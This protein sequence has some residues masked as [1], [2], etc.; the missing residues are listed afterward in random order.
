MV[1][2]NNT[3]LYNFKYYFQGGRTLK[4]LINE[5]K[6]SQP[7]IEK[8]IED[9]FAKINLIESDED[10]AKQVKSTWANWRNFLFPPARR[11]LQEIEESNDSYFS[12]GT[13]KLKSSARLQEIK[14]AIK[15]GT[16]ERVEF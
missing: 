15:Y 2:I 14:I 10:I 8:A 13:I 1:V 16:I 9:L 4:Y 5:R 3:L 12:S 11:V 6:V 7:K